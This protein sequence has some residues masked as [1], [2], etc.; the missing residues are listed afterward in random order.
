MATPNSQINEI[1]VTTLRKRTGK[2]ADN[3]SKNNALLLRLSQKGRSK[4]VR[5]GRTIVQEMEFTENST[6]K[7]YAGYDTLNISPS[8]VFTAAEYNYAQAGVAVSISGLE[9]IQNSGPEALIDLLDSRI[10]NAERTMKNNISSD[11]YS[12]GTADGG[13]Q[14]GGLQ[15]LVAD[16][17]TN[18]IG[19]ISGSTYTFWRNLV[20]DATTDFGAA[21]TSAN[22]TSYMNRVWL[23]IVRGTDKPDLII[24]DSNYY[25]LYW[26]SL[27]NIQRITSD[28]G[29]G[30]AAAGFET[31]KFKSA[32]VVF[33]GGYGGAAPASHMYFLNTDYLF[34]RPAADRNM[35]VVGGE[36]MAVNQ[37]AMVKLILW[38]GNMT[39]SNRFLQGVLKD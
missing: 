9:M 12:D 13:K 21:A 16:V 25:R 24:A 22:I 33:D 2:L 8:E 3:V 7:R 38:A 19:G 30:M 26:E 23:E 5:G 18:T 28:D 32:D 36:R 39:C 15:A 10:V 14:I 29:K 31:L 4:P 1:A 6:F 35:E 34:W 11:C 17:N 20:R 27:Q 37:D